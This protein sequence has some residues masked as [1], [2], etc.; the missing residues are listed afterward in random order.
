MAENRLKEIPGV[1]EAIAGKLAE[2]VTTGH[3]QYYDKLRAEFPEGIGAF[4]EVPGIGPRT[5]LLLARDLKITT[6]DE[7]EKAIEDGRV[8]N[9]P[10]MGEKTAQNILHQIKAF[11]KKKSEQRIPLGT[12]LTVSGSPDRGNEEIYPDLKT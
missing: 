1:G 10:R 7:L 3:M 4:L 9:L 12:A 11:R 5:A 8:A 6:L 2:L